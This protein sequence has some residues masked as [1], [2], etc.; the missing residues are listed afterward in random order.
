MQHFLK[1]FT[2]ICGSS[3]DQASM[4]HW[5]MSCSS[6][7][8]IRPVIVKVWSSEPYQSFHFSCN[9]TFISL[10][11]K[12]SRGCRIN[13]IPP[14]IIAWR[15]LQQSRGVLSRLL[16]CDNG[17]CRGWESSSLSDHL[18]ICPKLSWPT[19]L[20]SIH[21]L[22][23]QRTMIPAGHVT[24]RSIF[25]LNMTYGG[26]FLPSAVQANITVKRLFSFLVVFSWMDGTLSV[27]VLYGMSNFSGVWSALPICDRS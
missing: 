1:A 15:V 27:V 24:F 12:T 2:M 11:I 17:S 23:W 7:F 26:S 14:G 5:Q 20:L 6:T 9:I 16:T 25:R 8:L 22:S 10:L 13:V 21:P 4:I 3:S 19:P 18:F